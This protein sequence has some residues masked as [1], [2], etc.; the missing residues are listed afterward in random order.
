MAAI[1]IPVF[2]SSAV[3]KSALAIY[4]TRKNFVEDYLPIQEDVYDK[5]HFIDEKLYKFLVRDTAGQES[6][7]GIKPQ[8]IQ[9]NDAFILVYDLNHIES[10]P[11][12]EEVYKEIQSVKNLMLF[13]L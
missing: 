2:G 12:I 8:F 1:K 3:G 9:D 6:F 7:Q 4:F 13:R 10:L 5:K 11:D